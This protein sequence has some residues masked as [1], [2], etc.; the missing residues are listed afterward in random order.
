MGL[1]GQAALPEV[2]EAIR[3]V[4]EACP[5]AGV[6]LGIFGV[7]A[8]AVVPYIAQGYTLIIAGVDTLMLGTQARQILKQ[9]AS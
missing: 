9:L 8:E 4:T 7:T 1:I 6:P 2:Q 5:S 3:R